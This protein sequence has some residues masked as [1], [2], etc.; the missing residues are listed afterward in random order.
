M[1]RVIT[2][3]LLGMGLMVAATTL[4]QSQAHEGH[5]GHDHGTTQSSD[6]QAPSNRVMETPPPFETLDNAPGQGRSTSSSTRNQTQQAEGNW[7]EP[8]DRRPELSRPRAE[9]GGARTFP[10][11]ATETLPRRID[12]DD[13]PASR[14]RNRFTHQ[15]WAPRSEGFA[16]PLSS[17]DA[18]PG[19]F[20]RFRGQRD[21][22]TRD[23]SCL[24]AVQP[25]LPRHE[26]PLHDLS[27]SS[28]YSC[29]VN[30]YQIDNH[31]TSDYY[32]SPDCPFVGGESC[33][34]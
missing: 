9:A 20:L 33:G 11:A 8:A 21:R 25:R 7:S 23:G 10:P 28:S 29:N 15:R 5:D 34:F 31:L 12:N 13:Y 1:T 6:P 19:D 24:R 16:H 3:C 18:Y 27:L 32:T 17:E 26:I 2:T 22:D 14:S 4:P 30:L